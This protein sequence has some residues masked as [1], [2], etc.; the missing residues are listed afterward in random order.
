MSYAT[1]ACSAHGTHRPPL[2]CR[3][4]SERTSGTQEGRRSSVKFEC[5]VPQA[6]VATDEEFFR[7][8]VACLPDFLYCCPIKVQSGVDS[9]KIGGQT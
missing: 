7:Q 3:P 2:S 4:P 8:T 1:R 6:S 9:I 5:Y